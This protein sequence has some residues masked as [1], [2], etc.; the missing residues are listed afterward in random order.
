MSSAPE[1]R[2]PMVASGQ[3]SGYLWF[4][5]VHYRHVGLLLFQ[6]EKGTFQRLYTYLSQIFDYGN[7]DIE[8][9]SIFFRQVFVFMECDLCL[10][11]NRRFVSSSPAPAM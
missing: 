11:H 10:R 3:D 5:H 1:I 7:T 6:Q 2:P 9:R 8:M 4:I